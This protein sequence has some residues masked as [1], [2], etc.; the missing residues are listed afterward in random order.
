MIDRDRNIW[1]AKFT[2][3]SGAEPSL[4]KAVSPSSLIVYLTVVVID[5]MV[6]VEIVTLTLL[7]GFALLGT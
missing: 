1:Y 6:G 7:P 3:G 5:G 4:G 2:I